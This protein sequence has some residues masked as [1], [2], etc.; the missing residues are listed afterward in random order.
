MLLATPTPYTL[1]QAAACLDNPRQ[2]AWHWLKT[3]NTNLDVHTRIESIIAMDLCVSI[4]SFI[5]TTYYWFQDLPTGFQLSRRWFLRFVLR[6]LRYQGKLKLSKKAWFIESHWHWRVDLV[7]ECQRCTRQYQE[8]LTKHVRIRYSK[9]HFRK[10]FLR[11]GY[12]LWWRTNDHVRIFA[13]YYCSTLILFAK[14]SMLVLL[15]STPPWWVIGPVPLSGTM[16]AQA[17]LQQR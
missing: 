13:L 2:L 1:Q 12:L 15:V 6:W 11:Y 16:D 5:V 17:L 8:W 4:W 10:L 14:F 3:A 9:S 7:L